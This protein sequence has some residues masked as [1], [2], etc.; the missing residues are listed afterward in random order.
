MQ[1]EKIRKVKIDGKIMSIRN[2]L[3]KY[4]PDKIIVSIQIGD[5][6][7]KIQKQLELE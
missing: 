5:K 6:I 3:K 1:M 4:F 7:Y 2:Y